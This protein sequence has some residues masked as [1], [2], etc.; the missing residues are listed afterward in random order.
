MIQDAD[1][2]FFIFVSK[3]L[4]LKFYWNIDKKWKDKK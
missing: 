2:Y 3:K 4:D 1:A